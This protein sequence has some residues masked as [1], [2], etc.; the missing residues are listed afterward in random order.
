MVA[1]DC[2]AS[3]WPLTERGIE[4][5]VHRTQQAGLADDG[6]RVRGHHGIGFDGDLDVGVVALDPHFSDAAHYDIGYHYR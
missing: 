2:E 6:Y 3:L 4:L 5:D 1:P